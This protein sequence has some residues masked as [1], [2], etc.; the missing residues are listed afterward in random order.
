MEFVFLFLSALVTGLVNIRGLVSR[1]SVETVVVFKLD[2]LGDLVTAAPALAALRQTHPGVEITLV[3]GS[4]TRELAELVRSHDRLAVYDSPAFDRGAPRRAAPDL[5]SALPRARFDLAV[6]LRDDWSTL[7]FCLLGGARRRRD[8]G[9]VRLADRL[10]RWA[11]V[12]RGAGDPG[13]LGE[14]ATNLR[15][16][17]A[18]PDGRAPVPS[19]AVPE[20]A[21]RVL[22]E[23]ALAEWAAWSAPLVVVHPGAGWEHRRWPAERYAELVGRLLERGAAVAVTGSVGERDLARSVARPDP[24]CLALAGDLSLVELAA[25]LAGAAAFVGAD[26]GVTHLAVAVGTPVVALF[27]PGDPS[28]FGSFRPGD[29]VCYHRVACAPCRQ[30]A[31]D[32]DG[33]CM[34]AISVDEVADAVAAVLERSAEQESE[35]RP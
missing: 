17:G 5:T 34:R 23:G 20:D 29:T 9:T 26:T 32:D 28:R 33:A 27:G 24:S 30:V 35:A 11:S 22:A 21:K 7:R 13:P 31:C 15:V 14:V 8:R 4:W 2:H 25:L 3:V 12:V 1:G 16:V 18:Q 10:G 19:I 6:G